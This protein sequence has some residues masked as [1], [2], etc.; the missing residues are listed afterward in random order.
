MVDLPTQDQSGDIT[1]QAPVNRVS[2]RSYALSGSYLSQG[3]DKLANGLNELNV[4]L[5]Q[6]LAAHQLADGAVTRSPDG[7]VSVAPQLPIMGAGGAAYEH[8]ISAGALAMGDNQTRVDV[9]NLRAQHEGDPAGFQQAMTAYSDNIRA[10]NPGILG[11]SMYQNATDVGAQHYASMIQ[12]KAVTDTNDAKAS[13]DSA[14][15]AK[16][17]VLAA[18]AQ[19]GQ[20]GSPEYQKAMADYQSLSNSLTVNPAFGVTKDIQ[21]ANDDANTRLLQGYAVTA[22]VDKNW[23]GPDG[24]IGAQKTL[25][26]EIMNPAAGLSPAQ[27]QHFLAVG[28]ARIQYLVGQNKAAVEANTE[29]FRAFDE[30][31]KNPASGAKLTEPLW[32]A[33]LANS[34]AVGDTVTTAKLAAMHQ[35]WQ[36]QE[37]TKTLSPNQ[38]LNQQGIGA[39]APGEGGSVAT[40]TGLA[41]YKAR[42]AQIESGGNP[43]AVSPAGATGKYQFMPATAAQYGGNDEAAMDRLTAANHA[44]LKAGLGREPTPAEMYLAHQQ[45][46]GGALHLLAEP[47]RRAGDI[48]GDAAINGNGGN[49]NMTAGDFA[50]MWQAKYNRTPAAS[51][52]GV[53]YTPAEY[54][55]NPFLLSSQVHSIASDPENRVAYG[56]K[57]GESIAQSL[58]GGI[59]PAPEIMAN[60]AQLASTEPR[61]QQQGEHIQA[62]FEGMALGNKAINMPPGAGQAMI[63]HVTN[64]A[65]GGSLYQ[66]EVAIQARDFYQKGVEAL[67]KDPW[68][69][70]VSKG[71]DGGKGEPDPLD[72]TDATKLAVALHQRSDLASSIAARTGNNSMGALAP[73]EVET[74]KSAMDGP[75]AMNVASALSTLPANRMNGTLA[76]IGEKGTAGQVLAIAGSLYKD[77][78]DVAQDITQGYLIMRGEKGADY[79]PKTLDANTEMDKYIPN[80]TFGVPVREGL[81]NAVTA[82]YAKESADARDT[83][84]NFNSSRFEDAV[85]RVTGGV[86]DFHGGQLIAPQRGMSQRDFDN[87]VRGVGDDDLKGAVTLG[88]QP[89][90]GAVFQNGAKLENAGDGKYFVRLGNNDAK[91][92]YAYAPGQ[93]GAMSKFVL[94]LKDRPLSLPGANA[95]APVGTTIGPGVQSGVP[96]GT[97]FISIGRPQPGNILNSDA[98]GPSL[99]RIF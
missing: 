25:H 34:Q 42:T 83:S 70:A 63:D 77:A 39:S 28:E 69:T 24:I 12:Q 21:K 43:D 11:Q 4:P 74:I 53:P 51:V 49:S 75:N 99:G 38:S 91:P 61:L 1:A 73:D 98:P 10:K 57:L 44:T 92:I 13:I 40:P 18:M 8:A 9:A 65:Q 30:A 80:A 20:A 50:A 60:Y 22:H 15:T 96:S 90:T 17:D 67:K 64:L 14:M 97:P 47:S 45:G 6:Q 35:T 81:M 36:Q 71:W 16:F 88:G 56:E 32:Q 54:K 82:V 31:V 26:D 33:A 62:Q 23:N 52:N 29:N 94:D 66:S 46:A 89:V 27:Q 3:L 78:P 59:V 7:T 68:G 37:A 93:N 85:N 86:L 72:V 2:A 87:V 58:K 5:S 48:V 95:A 41:A 55:A 84:G 79:A 19:G 76:Q